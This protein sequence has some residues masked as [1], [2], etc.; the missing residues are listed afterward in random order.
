M[1]KLNPE[2]LKA[3][4]KLILL[5]VLDGTLVHATT[6]VRARLVKDV[7]VVETDM[8]R[9]SR[10]NRVELECVRRVDWTHT[11]YVKLRKN[12]HQFLQNLSTMFELIAYSKNGK[13]YAQALMNIVDPSGFLFKHRL[14]YGKDYISK[15]NSKEKI[16]H[17]ICPGGD[18]SM[19]YAI[20][21]P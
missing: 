19:L 15:A 18:I 13:Q 21:T 1:M 9:V 3:D 16:L 7:H 20:D 8:E 17:K 4:R 10:V 11:Y 12:A 6:E 2:K 5:V 14:I